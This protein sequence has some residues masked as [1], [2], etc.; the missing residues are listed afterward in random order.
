[1]SKDQLNM[2]K[3]VLMVDNYLMIYKFPNPIFTFINPESYQGYI[4]FTGNFTEPTVNL[5]I[6]KILRLNKWI[7]KTVVKK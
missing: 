4:Q 3:Q 6:H 1:M 5:Q 7:V 2:L